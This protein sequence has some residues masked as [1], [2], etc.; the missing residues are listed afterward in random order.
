MGDVFRNPGG[1]Q[2]RR[3]QDGTDGEASPQCGALERQSRLCRIVTSRAK[4]SEL[5]IQAWEA[6]PLWA[7]DCTSQV[8]VSSSGKWSVGRDV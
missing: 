5:W 2:L 7:N 6:G 1:F 8:S 3:W 4:S